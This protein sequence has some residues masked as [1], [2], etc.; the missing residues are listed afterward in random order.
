MLQV[1][2]VTYMPQGVLLTCRQA[3]HLC[4]IDIKRS[5]APKD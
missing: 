2:L 1:L 5:Y 4:N 3:C